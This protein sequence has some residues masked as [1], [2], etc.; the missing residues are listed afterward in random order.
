MS[1]GLTFL[2]TSGDGLATGAGLASVVDGLLTVPDVTGRPS[3]GLSDSKGEAPSAKY[4]GL[5][6]FQE[7]NSSLSSPFYKVPVLTS[8]VDSPTLL[9][10]AKGP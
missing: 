7:C 3:F 2:T 10:M 4:A 9:L 5:A 8:I 6:L 1:T